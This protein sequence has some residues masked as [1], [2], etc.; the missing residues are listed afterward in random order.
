MKKYLISFLVLI[1]SGFVYGQEPELDKLEMLYDQ[2]HY[3]KVYRKS[4]KLLNQPYYDYSALPDLYASLSLFQLIRDEKYTKRN[5]K[6]LDEAEEYFQNFVNEDV[7][8]KAYQMHIHEIYE[9]QTYLAKTSLALRDKGDTQISARYSGIVNRLFKDEYTVEEITIKETPTTNQN[10]EDNEEV[11]TSVNSKN[12]DEVIQYAEQFL[13]I[14]YKYGSVDPKKGFDCS[15][16]TSH[17][18]KKFNYYLPRSSKDQDSKIEKV[19]RKKV[20]KGDLVFFGNP[21]IHHVGIVHDVLPN[22]DITMIHAS[23]SL[24]ISI[25]NIDQSSYW[26]PRLKSF[27]RVIKD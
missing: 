22:G 6:A 13:G 24:G 10:K 8:N 4:K 26:S 3:K 5:P 1:I 27:G 14:K 9:L 23:T 20:Q 17:V 15:G 25:V 19:K 11:S 16:F 18:M 7:S 2:G 12:R 21:S